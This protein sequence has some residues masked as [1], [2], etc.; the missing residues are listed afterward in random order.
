MHTVAELA[1]KPSN[2]QCL[3]DMSVVETVM[4]LVANANLTVRMNVVLCLA[5]LT[6]H[7]EP[8]AERIMCSANQLRLLLGQT[9]GENVRRMD[10]D[11]ND[12]RGGRGEGSELHILSLFF[13]I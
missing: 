7:S 9:G 2:A 13:G 3:H 10:S 6:N 11:W 5:R 4:S 1:A 12:G 8:C